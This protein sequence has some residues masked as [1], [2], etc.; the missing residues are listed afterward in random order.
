MAAGFTANSNFIVNIVELQNTITSA[1]GLTPLSALSNQV[2]Q[3]AEMV[4]Y[5]DKSLAANSLRAFNGSNIAVQ[6]SMS[7][8]TGT[9]I[10]VDGTTLA[11]GGAGGAY[12][13]ISTIG[14]SSSLTNYYNTLSTAATAISFQ[15]G[16]PAAT[17]LSVTAGGTVVV[18]GT[19]RLA[20]TGTPGLGKYLTCMDATGTAEWVTPAM[21][22]D[23]R[24]KEGVTEL[25]DEAWAVLEAVR[26]VRF[27]WSG[28]GGRD[29][30]V[31]AQDLMPV[32]PEAVIE[33]VDGRPHMVHYHKLIPVLVETVK[34]LAR[35]VAELERGGG[36][37][38][39]PRA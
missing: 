38:P 22:S 39:P 12:S 10:T 14:F 32:L 19:L 17:P 30:G 6:N 3:I 18:D 31:I 11:G 29:V 21:P 23:G 15:V 9:T 25:G 26:G 13:G 8:A 2:A 33:G 16:L 36:R 7:F 24:W 28:G 37:G 4:N 35:R 20:G 5:G 34:D 1:S 27:R